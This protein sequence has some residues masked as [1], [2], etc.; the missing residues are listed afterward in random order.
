MTRPPSIALVVEPRFPGGTSSAVAQELAV[1]GESF[2][3][4][5]H[6]LSSRMFG[7][8]APAG[9]L[10]DALERHRIP[11]RMNAPQIAADLVVLHNPSFLKLEETLATRIV[12]RELVVVTHENLLRP[13][14]A[15]AFDM[16]HC[17]RLIDGSSLAVRK[18]LAPVSA[19]NR[20]TVD[21]WLSAH[22]E[23]G[24]WS[25]LGEDWANICDFEKR[26]PA[27][28]PADRR[29]RHSRPGWEKYP[30]LSDLD[31]C[32]PREADANVIVG[33]D[34][35]I[36][37]GLKRPHWRMI[38]FK[39]I[40]IDKYFNMIDFMVYFTAP[41]WRESFGRVIAEGIAAGKVVICDADTASGFAGGVIPARPA[42]VSGI[43][44]DLVARPDRY[45]DH[46]AAGQKAL[47][48][49]S[50][51]TFL[52]RRA[53]LFSRLARRAA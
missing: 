1:L 30:G 36:G 33:A 26:A 44:A 47:A 49:F 20:S 10:L 51:D 43:V 5:V 32:F 2:A 27:E 25:V 37:S 9:V 52:A 53:P 42:E 19:Y 15:E 29:G 50:S 7:D 31:H 38:P 45:A 4:E 11:L 3:V 22:P 46:V 14:G 18:S 12:A 8:R 34:N 17:L 35:L 6:G 24:H 23:F 13:G 39:G 41:T 21:A 40:E 16:A 48:A 28:R